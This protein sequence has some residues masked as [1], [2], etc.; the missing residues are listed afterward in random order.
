MKKS[1][2][3]L[4][5]LIATALAANASAPVLAFSESEIWLAPG[6]SK[7]VHIVLQSM[8]E[9]VKAGQIGLNVYD[10]TRILDNGVVLDDCYGENQWF[11]PEG[12][13]SPEI[14]Y[15]NSCRSNNTQMGVYT[16]VFMNLRTNFY[17][18]LESFTGPVNVFAFTVHATESWNDQYATIELDRN[19]SS[20]VTPSGT[21]DY[22]DHFIEPMILT[23][24]NKAADWPVTPTPDITTETTDDAVIVTAVGN[25]EVKLYQDGIEVENPCVVPRTY[26]NQT[27]L[28]GA[29]ARED[30]KLMSDMMRENVSIPALSYYIV[31]NAPFGD[32][33]TTAG[34]MMT[35]N[36]DGTYSYVT[37]LDGTVWFV[38]ASGLTADWGDWE[39]F[40]TNYR[41]GP[42][43]YDVVVGLDEWVATPRGGNTAYEFYG[44]AAEYTITFDP[45]NL[46]FKIEFNDWVMRTDAPVITSELYYDY[47][48]VSAIG[49]GEVS[50]YLEGELVENPYYV[51]RTDVDQTLTFSATAHEEGKLIS[52]TAT[53]VVTVPAM[54]LPT[55]DA[56]VITAET[57]ADAVTVT[58]IGNG[59][60]KL[61]QD[62]F[63][64][65]NPCVIPRTDVDRTFTFTATCKEEGK[66][67]SDVVTMTV[68]VPAKE[69]PLGDGISVYVKADQAPYLYSWADNGDQPCGGWP[70]M[71]LTDV[72]TINRVDY[73]VYT[74]DAK[75]SSINLILNNGAG[76]YGS[77]T[78][79]FVGITRD[80]YFVYDGGG[81]AYG[82]IPPTVYGN[83]TGE[84]AFYVNTDHWSE[85]YAVVDG[86]SYPMTLVDV[87]GAGYEVYKWEAEMDG[88]PSRITFSDGY[89]NGVTDAVGN[90][91]DDPYVKGGYYVYTFFINKSYADLDR[92]ATI[93]Y[94]G[95][96][97]V[98]VLEGCAIRLLSDEDTWNGYADV[99]F[100]ITGTYFNQ[101][102]RKGNVY[103]SV[104][105][106]QYMML[107]GELGSEDTFTEV[108][109]LS[110]DPSANDHTITL[111]SRDESGAASTVVTVL[112]V[113]DIKQLTC[114]NIKDYDYT[115]AAI[116]FDPE[117]YY[118]EHL[119][120]AGEDYEA[121]FLNNVEP[122]TATLRLQG[123]PLGYMGIKDFNFTINPHAISGDVHLDG[124]APWYY[125]TGSPITPAVVVIDD[126]FGTLT[127]GQ[128]YEVTY[129]NNDQVGWGIAVVDGIG[130]FTGHFELPFKIIGI[131]GDVNYSGH[132]DITDLQAMVMY[133][134]GEYNRPFNFTAA[135]LNNDHVVNVQDVV[136][137]A[138][139][140]LSS[141]Q[142]TMTSG[143][144]RMP[145]SSI[146]TQ[147]S[148]Y[149]EN[150]V[151]YLYSTVPVAALDIVNSVDGDI[152][153]NLETRGMVVAN[154]P[155][156]QG[157]HSV[158]YSL[159]DVVIPAGLTAI[160]TTT[161]QNATVIGAM[162]S[163]T[164]AEL[165]SL[166]LNDSLTGITQVQEDA[167]ATCRMDGSTLTIT[168]G[169]TLN[170]VDVTIYSIDGKIISN[171]KLGRLESGTASIDLSDCAV[172]DRY[173]IIVVRSGR[174]VLSTKKLTTKR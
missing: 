165:I 141:N 89:G 65:D 25:G 100:E 50:L 72:T 164:D 127:E 160:A 102:A 64:V 47:V 155:C 44:N 157:E 1:L 108:V 93:A 57:T 78:G 15:G 118:N 48:E 70:G 170:D 2:S 59:E 76:G 121:S 19:W 149:W 132:V 7:E 109:T 120:S 85:V 96:D 21:Y 42:S 142:L 53:L 128:D 148:L 122:G 81:F 12:P 161:G 134:F 56:P 8:D 49:D 140:L 166:K 95:E 60:V 41:Y 112:Q 146:D 144:R 105:G 82:V 129:E 135:D 75:Y 104:D 28:F 123:K 68:L 27:I 29:T 99:E 167:G 9:T 171:K 124:D 32:W 5:A 150:G 117:V 90:I 94:A 63:E 152:R 36:G 158:I 46:C 52:E 125:Y 111:I 115:G 20:L 61:Y 101:S 88:T 97:Q 151:L 174:Q 143:G 39:T 18:P 168:T 69:Q 92:V 137:E 154:A 71:M 38:F 54:D 22:T 139:L 16:M 116:T 66:L 4:M 58:A 31:G 98:P 79:D 162:L 119:L 86:V 37:D 77:Q 26:V 172:E 133:I 114:A 103:Y 87:D 130:H 156:A 106:S 35:P 3:F 45:E 113:T 169:T 11:F 33:N 43:D 34:V 126:T 159:G 6:E 107:T 138:N 24:K 147:A 80:A 110:F 83:P 13:S 55:S 173:Y 40:N 17:W 153:W 23:V 91:Y 14:T 30:G 131:P 10:P 136:G 67:I 51:P 74:F 84:Y 145:A 73:Y 163:D 62:G